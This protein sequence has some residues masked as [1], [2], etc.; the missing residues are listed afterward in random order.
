MGKELSL[1]D[2]LFKKGVL[3]EFTDLIESDGFG[4]EEKQLFREGKLKTLNSFDWDLGTQD[5]CSI[6]DEYQSQRKH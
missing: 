5:W 6:D 2:F 1:K 4:E 3:L